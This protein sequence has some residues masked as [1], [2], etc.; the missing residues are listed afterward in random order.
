MWI[1]RL[2]KY[3]GFIAVP[4]LGMIFVTLQAIGF[5]FVSIDPA[6]IG[7]LALVPEAVLD[8]QV[9][10]LVTFL[11]LPSST[12]L[13][14][15][16]LGLWFLW[17][18]FSALENE[19]GAFRT[20]LYVALSYVVMVTASFV[21]SAPITQVRH[22]ESSLFLAAALLYPNVELALFGVLPIQMKWLAVLT[23]VMTGLDFWNGS[24]T[25]RWMMLAVYSNFFVYFGPSLAQSLK[26]RIRRAKFK[27]DHRN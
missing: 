4:R 9:F 10:R 25:D 13:I 19:W 22:F 11:A 5:L 20:T 7:Q 17:F 26:A 21:L 18:V 16:L 14:W 24:G 27:R 23:A 2:E 1:D 12:S 6:W 15:V 8:G 3:L